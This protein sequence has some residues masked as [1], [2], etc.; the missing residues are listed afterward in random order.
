MQPPIRDTL[1]RVIQK[2]SESPRTDAEVV[3]TVVDL[4]NS[5]RVR[6]CGAFAGTRLMV[7][8]SLSA[9]LAW[10]RSPTSA[11]FSSSPV[12]TAPVKHAQAQGGRTEFL[13]V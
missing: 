5:G 3:A 6:P 7:R 8:P 11:S 10:V 2:V 13:M 9:F 12:A 4:I 1:F